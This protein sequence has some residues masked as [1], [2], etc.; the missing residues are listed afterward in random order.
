MACSTFRIC[1]VI[2]EQLARWKCSCFLPSTRYISSVHGLNRVSY[3]CA[4]VRLYSDFTGPPPTEPAAGA[5]RDPRQVFNSEKNIYASR[6]TG[7]HIIPRETD[8]VVIG[9]GLVG[10][11][12]AFWLKQQNP[13]GYSVTVIEQDDTASIVSIDLYCCNM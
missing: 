8:V 10:L 6:Q 3:S 5:F 11:S 12:T 4:G 1:R 13:T 2:S 9:G 7:K